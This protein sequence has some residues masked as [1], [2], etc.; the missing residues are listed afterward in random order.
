MIKIHGL[1]IFNEL[2]DGL[3]FLN[4]DVDCIRDEGY[5]HDSDMKV[6]RQEV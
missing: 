4:L 3:K 2:Q 6:K 5:D 1:I